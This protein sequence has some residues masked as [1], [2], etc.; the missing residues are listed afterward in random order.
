[1]STPQKSVACSEQRL[2]FAEEAWRQMV[3]AR[4]APEKVPGEVTIV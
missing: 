4:V 3:A 1:M 2:R